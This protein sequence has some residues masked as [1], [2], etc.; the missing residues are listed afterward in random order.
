MLPAT[1]PGAAVDG[2][3]RPH[4]DL[5]ARLE[6][7]FTRGRELAGTRTRPEV[8]ILEMGIVAATEAHRRHILTMVPDGHNRPVV[9]QLALA[10]LAVYNLRPSDHMPVEEVNIL[11]APEGSLHVGPQWCALHQ[12]QVLLAD[13]QRGFSSSALLR[14]KAKMMALEGLFRKLGPPRGE[15][16]TRSCVEWRL[17]GCFPGWRTTPQWMRSGSSTSVRPPAPCD[18]HGVELTT[19]QLIRPRGLRRW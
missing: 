8:D 2:L 10:A 12:P 6:R 1:A 13:L 15:T 3:W 17:L 14:I 9:M 16:V 19:G 7:L 11:W 4:T 18:P 5:E